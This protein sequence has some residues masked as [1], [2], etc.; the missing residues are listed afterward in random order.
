MTSSLRSI[1]LRDV[2]SKRSVY[3]TS[4]LKRYVGS[5]KDISRAPANSKSILVE[6]LKK[7]KIIFVE[8]LLKDTNLILEVF[9]Q[10]A[11]GSKQ[12]CVHV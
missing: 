8:K 5:R 12:S 7:E 1:F 9:N 6:K 10:N 3:V 4:F 11:S 2:N